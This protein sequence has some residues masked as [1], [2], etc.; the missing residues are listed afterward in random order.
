MSDRRFTK[1]KKT[2]VHYLTNTAVG[3]ILRYCATVV[4]I[5]SFRNVQVEWRKM[6]LEAVVKLLLKLKAVPKKK[7]SSS[8]VIMPK[9]RTRKPRKGDSNYVPRPRNSWIIFRSER[10]EAIKRDEGKVPAQLVSKIVSE[11]WSSMTVEMKKLWAQRAEA[12]KRAHKKKFPDYRYQ[13]TRRVLKATKSPGERE[14]STLSS[15]SWASGITDRSSSSPP[16]AHASDSRPPSAT[17]FPDFNVHP[18]NGTEHHSGSP[19]GYGCYHENCETFESPAPF[20]DTFFPGPGASSANPPV[21]LGNGAEYYSGPPPA[22]YGYDHENRETFEGPVPF[23]DTFSARPVAS[24]ANPPVPTPSMMLNIPSL[25]PNDNGFNTQS[26]DPFGNSYNSFAQDS[27]GNVGDLS[28]NPPDI[29]NW[30]ENFLRSVDHAIQATGD[31]YIHMD[32]LEYGNLDISLGNVAGVPALTPQLQA[33]SAY[34]GSSNQLPPQLSQG[35]IF[36]SAPV[37]Q[38]PREYLGLISSGQVE[39]SQVAGS[40]QSFDE[41]YINHA[42]QDWSTTGNGNATGQGYY[43]K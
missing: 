6:S 16:S 21:H 14:L 26:Q 35:L 5:W 22:A 18:G 28:W 29:T 13:P 17:D 2:L 33:H 10:S 31:D 43:Y 11:E 41:A 27:N 25:G 12:E 3:S 20:N 1:L 32:Q 7:V 39:E 40:S 9:D 30:D 4:K 24:F 34:H 36:P 42:N 38:P 15:D 8:G 23:N 37:Q 19:T